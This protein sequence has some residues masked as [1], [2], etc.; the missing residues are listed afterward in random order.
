MIEV[1]ECD[2]VRIDFGEAE[3]KSHNRLEGGVV[4]SGNDDV[5]IWLSISDQSGVR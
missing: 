4:S 3:Y 2:R 5:C 1:I